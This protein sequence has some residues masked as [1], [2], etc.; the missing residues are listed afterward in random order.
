VLSAHAH[1]IN[2]G[3]VRIDA[4]PPGLLPTYSYREPLP[5]AR[6]VPVTC[7]AVIRGVSVEWIV[8][9]DGRQVRRHDVNRR[10]AR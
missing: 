3:R 6:A 2:G 4:P 8:Q 9:A 10:T 5:R 1:H 7:V